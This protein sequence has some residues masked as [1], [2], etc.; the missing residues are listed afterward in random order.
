MYQRIKVEIVLIT[1]PLYFLI[2]DFDVTTHLDPDVLAFKNRCD[3][4]DCDVNFGPLLSSGGY[5]FLSWGELK[6]KLN[7]WLPPYVL[8]SHT[9]SRPS[10]GL[11]L[12]WDPCCPCSREQNRLSLGPSSTKR[13]VFHD[14]VVLKPR[15]ERV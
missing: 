5:S 7:F 14:L 11:R 8:G 13:L 10:S 2:P 6:D 15:H 3:Y 1:S 9:S 12:L 4:C